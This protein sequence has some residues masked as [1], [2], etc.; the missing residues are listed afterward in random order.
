MKIGVL[1]L[2]GD[3][4][5]HV[6]ALDRLLPP[7]SVVPVR[8]VEDL[9]RVVGLFLPGG[10][11]TTIGRLLEKTG[12]DRALK[13]R[14]Q[15]GFPVLATCAGLIL[16]ASDLEPSPGGRDPHPLG[17]LDVRVRRNDYG[18]QRESFEG[19]VA[20]EGLA[21]PFPGV[22]IRAPRI[23][24]VGSKATVVARHGTEVVGVRQE[25]L[26]G[27]TFHPELS[28]DARVHRLF[29]SETLGLGQP[30]TNQTTRRVTTSKALPNAT[31]DQN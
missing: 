17:L 11:S 9:E 25:N 14:A 28:G 22:F 12:L 19:P 15:S 13:S 10:E 27:L 3:V 23:L 18:R 29:L 30:S 6:A 8:R 21:A 7:E 20:V 5:E 4:P 2:Q 24:S 1:A 26:W 31:T 16:L